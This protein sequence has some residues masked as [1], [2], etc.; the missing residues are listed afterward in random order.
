MPHTVMLVCIFIFFI[1]LGKNF[2]KKKIPY[3]EDK[4]N[5]IEFR[6]KKLYL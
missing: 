2:K 6:G 5:L 4:F 3:E 1:K